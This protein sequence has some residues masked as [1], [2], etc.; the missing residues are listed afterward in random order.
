MLEAQGTHGTPS[1]VTRCNHCNHHSFKWYR[2]RSIYM[3]PNA[4]AQVVIR[5]RRE[6]QARGE[7]EPEDGWQNWV[8]EG[9]EDGALR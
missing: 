5:M 8:P 1:E 3:G 9:W 7:P 6:A 2:A 4:T